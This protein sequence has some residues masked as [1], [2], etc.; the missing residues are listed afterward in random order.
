M[1]KAK[2]QYRK[3]KDENNKL[4]RQKENEMLDYLFKNSLVENLPNGRKIF[5]KLWEKAWRD[6]HSSGY[7]AVYLDYEEKEADFIELY[8][9]VH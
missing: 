9:L 8:N 5:D 2:Q 4:I 3:K 1:E 6:S 7:Y